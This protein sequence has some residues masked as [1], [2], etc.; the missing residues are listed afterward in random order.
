[1]ANRILTS[2][3]MAMLAGMFTTP[4]AAR[5]LFSAPKDFSLDSLLSDPLGLAI[6]IILLIAFIGG[7][8]FVLHRAPTTAELAHRREKFLSDLPSDSKG[9]KAVLYLDEVFG[10]EV[11]AAGLRNH[12]ILV[13]LVHENPEKSETLYRNEGMASVRRGMY[14]D[15]SRE[16]SNFWLDAA[17]KYDLPAVCATRKA[18]QKLEA[19]HFDELEKDRDR[20]L[21]KLSKRMWINRRPLR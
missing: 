15:K 2:F 10:M 16:A 18:I 1:M 12:R 6:G 21:K 19:R 11:G 14:R 20:F 4:V 8:W 3:A 5:P 17:A 13:Q 9:Y 7:G